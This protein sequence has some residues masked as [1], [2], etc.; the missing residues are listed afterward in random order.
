MKLVMMD[1][2]KGNLKRIKD[3]AK[4]NFSGTTENFIQG[5]GNLA[6]K[7]GQACGN[8]EKEIAISVNGKMAKFR[9]MEFILIIQVNDMKV[10]LN[11]F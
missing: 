5:S 8:Q 11:N 4:E 2:L 7:M 1:I 10:I 6:I 9:D 3:M